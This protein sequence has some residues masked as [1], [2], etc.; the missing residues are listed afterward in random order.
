MDRFGS[1]IWR[2]FDHSSE[3]NDHWSETAIFLTRLSFILVSNGESN[4]TYTRREFS[5]LI[6][7][8]AALS[9]VDIESYASIFDDKRSMRLLAT[10]SASGEGFWKDLKFDGKIPRE[11][12]GSLFRTCPGKSEHFGTKLQHLFD[13]DAY[14]TRWDF[15]NGKASLTGRFLNTAA[16]REELKEGKMIYGEYGTRAPGPNKGGKNQPSVNVI[17]WRGKLL[18]LSEGGLPSILD[19]KTL[20]F[21]G[22]E[23]FD[24]VVPGYLTF[25]AHPRFDPTTGDMFAWGFEKRP[26]GTMHIIRVSRSSGEAETL[27]KVPQRGFQMVHDA[28]L[29]ENYFVILIVP[30]PYDLAK[31]QQGRPMG[32]ALSFAGKTPTYLYA[33]PRDNSDG[34]KK[35]ITIELPPYVIFHY[36]NAVETEGN[37]LRFEAITSTDGRILE[38]LR[39]WREDKI[40]EY[41]KPMLKQ[42][43]VDL[44]KKS[45][46]GTRDLVENV[47]F[48]RYDMRLTGKNNRFMY[49]AD[50]LYGENASVIKVD[51]EKGKTAR[52][53]VGK[54]RTIAEPVF[55]PGKNS[56]SEDDGWI[57][58]LGYDA[59]KNEN[60]LEILNAQNLDF[61]ARIWAGG[62]HFPLGFHG[63]YSAG[64]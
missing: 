34:T 21:E 29:T 9:L 51:V 64:S 41:Q 27:Y 43:E 24:G 59:R 13:G 42:I 49:V 54:G 14:L 47:E 56:K 61:A 7:G 11:L 50:E 44:G 17:E 23:S 10:Q 16:R 58:A 37:R 26:P 25:T 55:V 12:N 63:N 62:Q 18:G 5:K 2:D 40:P 3:N 32:E 22:Y 53:S 39:N 57:L 4:M 1:K 30:M 31:L 33:F 35:P 19:P 48:P 8:A 38:V 45:V 52:S 36:G 6:F 46:V 60:F 15:Q 28:M 20:A